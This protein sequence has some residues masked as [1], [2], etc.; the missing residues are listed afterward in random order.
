MLLGGDY[1]WP[2]SP[3]VNLEQASPLS[4]HS[5][6]CQQAPKAGEKG[7][8]RKEVTI[9]L[10]LEGRVT[11]RALREPRGRSGDAATSTTLTNSSGTGG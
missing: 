11:A 2:Y 5:L 8:K 6:S 9:F 7:K 1:E 3:G 4:C 10:S